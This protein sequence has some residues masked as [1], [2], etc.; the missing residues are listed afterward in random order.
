[1]L[2]DSNIL[3]YAINA[4]SP[5][6]E[7]AKRFLESHVQNLQISHQ[8]ILE[9]LR[10]ITHST[11]SHPLNLKEGLASV[12]SLVQSFQIIVPNN[13]TY[14]VCLELIKKHKLTGNRIFDAYL[15]ATAL[16]NAT[17][18][19]ATDN[20]RDFAKIKEIKVINPFKVGEPKALS[21]VEGKKES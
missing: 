12:L 19:I 9:A 15:A 20:E 2:V 6:H 14:Y 4:D 13:K 18:E 3:I 11:F 1:M 17:F 8:N 7:R 21:A 16:T 10:V 5:K